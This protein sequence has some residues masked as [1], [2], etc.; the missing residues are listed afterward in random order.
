MAMWGGAVRAA[1]EPETSADDSASEMADKP[2]VFDTNLG[3]IQR[4]TEEAIERSLNG[5]K[6]PEGAEIQLFPAVSRDGDWFVE[7]RLANYLS[8]K[9]Y[10][11]YLVSKEKPA[12]KPTN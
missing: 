6:L 7:D 5:I 3:L 9:G 2:L 10:K 8:N 12:K 4:A 11:V 1:D